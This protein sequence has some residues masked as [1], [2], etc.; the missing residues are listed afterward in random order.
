MIQLYR[1]VKTSSL[2]VLIFTL[3]PLIG[4]L[5]CAGKGSRIGGPVQSKPIAYDPD[6][7]SDLSNTRRP[8]SPKSRQMDPC[9]R[10]IHLWRPCFVI[11]RLARWGTS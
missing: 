2:I 9:G 4:M 5:G 11:K 1:T 6:L 7:P 8:R 10:R 3:I